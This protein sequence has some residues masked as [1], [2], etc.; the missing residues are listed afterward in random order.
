[1]TV[2]PPFHASPEVPHLG[3][4]PGSGANPMHGLA[5]WAAVFWVIWMAILP[6][7]HVTALRNALALPVILLAL[8]VA[9]RHAGWQS[10]AHVPAIAPWLLLISWCLLSLVWS[11]APQVSWSKIRSDL[12]LPFGAYLSAYVL[13]RHGGA[14]RYLLLGPMIGTTLLLLLS[15]F[16]WLP[17]PIWMKTDVQFGTVA[18]MPYWYPGI[19]D[20]S[21]YAVLLIGPLLAWW[22]ARRQDA[23]VIRRH[24]PALAMIAALII[25]V[26]T[27]RRNALVVALLVTPMFFL[28]IA[29]GRKQFSF[30]FLGLLCA[31]FLLAAALVAAMFEF[32][33]RERLFPAER[34]ALP[35]NTSAALMLMKGEPRPRIWAYYFDKAQDHPWIGVG[36]GR[37]V[38]A[39]VFHANENDALKAIDPLAVIHAHNIMLDWALQTGVVGLALFFALLLTVSR[40]AWRKRGQSREHRLLAAAVLVTLIAM[41]LRNMTDDF[42][43]YCIAIMFWATLGALLG[44]IERQRPFA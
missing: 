14:L 29:R 31:G 44:L 15:L 27:N 39:V 12:L 16:A 40:L 20:A 1:L 37:T 5:M 8:L 18:P 2:S 38:P 33:A 21:A 10:L 36:F 6:L 11:G 28:M 30:K 7:G 26:A 13:A 42:L 43:V 19:G 41:L 23:D 25:I 24:L 34:A 32:G 35:P 3:V 17:V 9:F 4:N 22:V